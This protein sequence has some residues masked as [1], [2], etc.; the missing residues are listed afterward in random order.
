MQRP[1]AEDSNEIGAEQDEGYIYTYQLG[2]LLQALRCKPTSF[3]QLTVCWKCGGGH[4][5]LSKGYKS[6]KRDSQ[7]TPLGRAPYNGCK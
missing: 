2:I 7:I 4:R 6:I 5:S 3:G 1:G